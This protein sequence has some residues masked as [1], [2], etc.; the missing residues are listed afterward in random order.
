MQQFTRYF[1]GIGASH[2]YLVGQ[3]ELDR[4]DKPDAF[5]QYYYNSSGRCIQYDI[6]WD[7][8]EPAGQSQPPVV[9][10]VEQP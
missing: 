2:A 8:A 10:F 3:L 6:I 4:L 7:L 9:D 1:A 5:V